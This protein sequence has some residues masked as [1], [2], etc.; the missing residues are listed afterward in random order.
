ML[1]TK[2]NPAGAGGETRGRGHPEHRP[3]SAETETEGWARGGER[4]EQRVRAAPGRGRLPT[5]VAVGRDRDEAGVLLLLP[6]GLVR[7]V[8]QVC[9]VRRALHAELHPGRACKDRPV[10]ARVGSGDHP[11]KPL[12]S[13]QAPSPPPSQSKL[14]GVSLYPRMWHHTH[15]VSARPAAACGDGNGG[16]EV[17]A[18]VLEHAGP[19]WACGGSCQHVAERSAMRRTGDGWPQS[20]ACRR[21]AV[22]GVAGPQGSEPVN[23]QACLASCCPQPRL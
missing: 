20:C 1:V 3:Q 15:H 11:G 23:T 10:S 5:K 14:P 2:S 12:L 21:D 7:P 9:Q 8:V 16:D 19:S 17:W 22:G 18:G 13:S 4:E 6:P